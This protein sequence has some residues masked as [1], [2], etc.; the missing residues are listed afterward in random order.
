MQTPNSFRNKEAIS[1]NWIELNIN[2]PDILNFNIKPIYS[3]VSS[4]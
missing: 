3:Y 4:D 1:Y 2:L